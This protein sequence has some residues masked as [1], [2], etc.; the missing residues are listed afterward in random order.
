[1][2]TQIEVERRFIVKLP[3]SWTA[4]AEMLDNVIDVK[5]I[6]QAYLIKKPGEEQAARVR[7]TIQGMRGKT[8]TK[9]EFNQKKSTGD[10][11]ANKE[12]EFSI[13]EKQYHNYLKQIDPN[14]YVVEKVRFV[15]KW[16]DQIFELDLFKGRLKGLAI[17]EIELDNS[18]HEAVELPPFLKVVKEITKDKRFNNFEMAKKNNKLIM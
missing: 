2:P 4:F 5:R 17:L 11:G 8:E 18:V 3:Q 14:Q 9:Y 12:K 13:T 15:F 10:T 16:H 7:K 6:E 1:M